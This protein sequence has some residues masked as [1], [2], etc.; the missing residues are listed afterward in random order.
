M[1]NFLE[2]L[3]LEE[4]DEKFNFYAKLSRFD[5]I[6]LFLFIITYIFGFFANSIL[7][8]SIF[9]AL[10]VLTLLRERRIG[11]EYDREDYIGHRFRNYFFFPFIV[12]IALI[13]SPINFKIT[14]DTLIPTGIKLI[15]A[16][17]LL[18]SYLRNKI[19]ESYIIELLTMLIIMVLFTVLFRSLTFAII[20]LLFSYIYAKFSSLADLII[21][22][23]IF[24]VINFYA[25]NSIMPVIFGIIILVFI[26]K[27]GWIYAGQYITLFWY[28]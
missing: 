16:V 8:T 20:S 27:K 5:F 11:L 2:L 23:I 26:L 9:T 6:S 17:I 24:P 19:K 28:K 7:T 22:A 25:I 10:S 1:I 4:C 3:K 13:T 21:S 15:G 12:S 14:I 18:T